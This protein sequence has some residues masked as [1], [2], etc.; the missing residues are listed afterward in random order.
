V[1]FKPAGASVPAA[2]TQAFAQHS[3]SAK[4]VRR[5]ARA[6][7]ELDDEPAVFNTRTPPQEVVE[8]AV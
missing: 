7:A 5:K 8:N 1:L 4:A 3:A 6:A 2:K